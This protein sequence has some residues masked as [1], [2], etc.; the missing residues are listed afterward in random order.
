MGTFGTVWNTQKKEFGTLTRPEKTIEERLQ[1]E[2]II[3]NLRRPK[4]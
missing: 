4:T 2:I 1:R 3:T